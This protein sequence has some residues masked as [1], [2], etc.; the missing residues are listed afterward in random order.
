MIRQWLRQW[1][2][3]EDLAWQQLTLKNRT[4]DRLTEIERWRT[5]LMRSTFAEPTP[6]QKVAS[7]KLG[8]ET[9]ARLLAEDA[10]RHHT[11][12]EGP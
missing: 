2:G 4:D 3:I 1:L 6:E 8:N 7:D 5:M 12:G 10:A 9:I 11:T